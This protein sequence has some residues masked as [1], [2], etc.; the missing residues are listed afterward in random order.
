MFMATV[1]I[2]K[3][4]E[5]ARD[6]IHKNLREPPKQPKPNDNIPYDSIK[7]KS[8]HRDIIVVYSNKKAYPS[9]LIT[10]KE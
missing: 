1:I 2:G 8:N 10:Y 3:S 6:E 5:L 4:V 7:G 9:Y